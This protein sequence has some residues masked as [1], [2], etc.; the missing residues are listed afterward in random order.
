MANESFAET[1]RKVRLCA[2]GVENNLDD[3]SPVGLGQETVDAG[4]DYAA[5]METLDAEQEALK[6]DLKTKTAELKAVR[7]QARQ[8]YSR[9]RKRIKIALENEQERWIEFGIKATR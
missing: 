2:D 9:T 5:R 1:I 6:A 3:V 8:W 7:K 4:R